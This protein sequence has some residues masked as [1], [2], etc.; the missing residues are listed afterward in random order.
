MPLSALPFYNAGI[1]AQPGKARK[2]RRQKRQEKFQFWFSHDQEESLLE[3]LEGPLGIPED[4][5]VM[6]QQDPDIRP[7]YQ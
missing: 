4:M 3:Q 2:S 1:E 5:G 7:L 6:Q